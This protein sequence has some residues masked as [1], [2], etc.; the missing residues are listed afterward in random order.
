MNSLTILSNEMLK[1]NTILLILL[2]INAGLDVYYGK[3]TNDS[4]KNNNWINNPLGIIG[5][6][7]IIICLILWTYFIIEYL[8]AI[9][10]IKN[11]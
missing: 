2:S 7:Y 1:K 5:I 9:N 8:A 4:E 6:I 10:V 3:P 11:K